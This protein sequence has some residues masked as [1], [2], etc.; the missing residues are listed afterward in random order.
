MSTTNTELVF[1]PDKSLK[2]LQFCSLRRRR[3]EAGD[4]SILSSPDISEC[5]RY[6]G[7]GRGRLLLEHISCVLYQIKTLRF[8]HGMELDDRWLLP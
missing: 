1:R 4:A 2:H 3:P 8:G 7:H 6:F 5:P